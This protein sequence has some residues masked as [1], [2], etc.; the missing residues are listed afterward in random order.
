MR[1]KCEECGI[2][3]ICNDDGICGDCE[4]EQQSDD[5]ETCE[6]CGEPAVENGRCKDDL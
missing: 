5:Q 1:Q 4:Y 3:S 2:F 6:V